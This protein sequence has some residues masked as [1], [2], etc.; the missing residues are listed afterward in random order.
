M[1]KIK[2]LTGQEGPAL[3]RARGQE[4]TIGV[5]IDAGEAQRLVD[6][7]LALDISADQ[8]T[9]AAPVASSPAPPAPPAAT[10]RRKS[11]AKP[12][13]AVKATA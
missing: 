13:P 2:M 9:L 8:V 3:S 6:S 5:D 11:P 4:L 1:D 10:A 12:N 7:D